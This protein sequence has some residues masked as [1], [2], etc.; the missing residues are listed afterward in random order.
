MFNPQSFGQMLPGYGF[1]NPVYPQ[2]PAPPQ[3]AIQQMMVTPVTGMAQ[4]EAAQAPFDG[5]PM[6]FYDTSANAVY[7][8]QFDANTG[9]APVSVYR[10]EPKA[11]PPQYATVEMLSDLARRVEE[12]ASMIQVEPVRH[13]RARKEAETE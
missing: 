6:F 7:I 1:R 5:T 3:Q 9:T 11:A 2:P 8:K 13:P 12:M 4:V 10:M